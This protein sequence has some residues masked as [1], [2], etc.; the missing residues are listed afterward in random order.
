MITRGSGM[1]VDALY[2]FDDGER[3]L[4]VVVVEDERVGGSAA[5]PRLADGTA[6][7]YI[8]GRQPDKDLVNDKPLGQV[9]EHGH[10]A[11]VRHVEC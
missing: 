4:A 5:A 3:G 2:V 1:A 9:V 8:L 7:K 11:A 6:P 10:A